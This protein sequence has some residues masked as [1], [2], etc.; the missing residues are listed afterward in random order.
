MENE[1]SNPRHVIEAA[2]EIRQ[3]AAGSNDNG[4]ASQREQISIVINLGSDV[5]DRIERTFDVT[6]KTPQL[7]LD[8]GGKPDGNEWG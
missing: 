7:E 4:P 2:K 3:A 1:A 5:G 6:P 8:L